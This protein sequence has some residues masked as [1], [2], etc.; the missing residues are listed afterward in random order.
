MD[1][2]TDL[3]LKMKELRKTM[4]MPKVSANLVRAVRKNKI[5]RKSE[6]VMLFY[7]TKYEINLTELFNDDKNFFLPR[8]KCDELEVCPYKS[9]DK[10][11][12]SDFGISEPLTRAVDKDILDLVIVPALCADKNGYRLGYGG[13]Y[14]DRFLSDI[15]VKTICAV[16][17]ELFL[18]SVPHENFDIQIDEIIT[19]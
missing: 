12:K 5:Y 3:R 19:A 15:H 8:V 9:G 7:P 16:P 17:E 13:G 11:N 10:L 4:D 6:N 18:N 1:N 14:Y 2:K